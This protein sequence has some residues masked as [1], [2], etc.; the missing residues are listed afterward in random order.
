MVPALIVILNALP[1]VAAAL[2]GIGVPLLA[3]VCHRRLGAGM[4]VVTVLFALEL[5][6]MNLGGVRL[7]MALYY[8][9]IVLLFVAAVAAFRFVFA[10]DAPRLSWVWWI[11]VAVFVVSL[12]TGLASFGSAAGVQARSYFYAI[13][14]ACYVGSFP[15]H[16]GHVRVALNLLSAL[17]VLML[18]LVAYRWTV[19]YLPIPSLLPEEGAYNNDG[20]IRVIRSFEALVL[21]QL[22]VVG[23]FFG[24]VGA[25][26]RLV[27]FL[28]PLLLAAVVALQHRSVWVAALAGVL[29]AML[30][31]R[32]RT[33]S[34]LGQIALLASVLAITAMPAL[35]SDQLGG[36]TGQVTSSAG[37]AIALQ[38]TAGERLDGWSDIV[39]RWAGAGP[40]SIAIGQ[41][42]GTDNSRYVHDSTHGGFRKVDYFAHNFYVQSLFN[43]GLLGVLAFVVMAGQVVLNLYRRCA[44]GTGG[45]AVQALL[46]LVLMQLVYYVPYG[47]DYLQNILLGLGLGLTA[48]QHAG[49]GESAPA[50]G[51]RAWQRWGAA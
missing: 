45:P 13:A 30:V 29:A 9:D 5:L 44:A 2:L 48:R 36:V 37:N 6:Y 33:G 7:G 27:R 38:G 14:V 50:A 28:S 16:E 47:V 15:V 41:S 22:L 42:F 51:S 17:G 34:R 20:A 18:A 46:V 25:G 8:A 4:A 49:T 3:V 19:Y 11:F 21:A 1:F 32:S 39:K 10:A 40:R 35:F 43:M 24:S 23:L 26:P 31:G 12:A